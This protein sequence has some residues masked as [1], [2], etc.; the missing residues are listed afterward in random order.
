MQNPKHNFM[1]DSKMDD[2][3]VNYSQSKENGAA[4]LG[5]DLEQLD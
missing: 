3:S 1:N 5:N 4:D 2:Q